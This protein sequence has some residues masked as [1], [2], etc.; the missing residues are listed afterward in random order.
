MQ[1]RYLIGQWRR[2]TSSPPARGAWAT[3]SAVSSS[4][5]AT[6]GGSTARK[7]GSIV[8]D[9]NAS[10]PNGGYVEDFVEGDNN[11]NEE[12]WGIC[13]KGAPDVR[14]LYDVYPRAAYYALR[15][16]FRLDPYAPGTDLGGRSAPTSQDPSPRRRRAE[17]R[18]SSRQ[19]RFELRLQRVRVSG[20]RLEFETYQHRRRANDHDAGCAQRRC[21]RAARRSGASTTCS[22]STS[23]SRRS[24]TDN[25]DREGCRST[26]SA[27]CRATRSTRSSTRTAARPRPSSPTAGLVVID[28]LERVKVYHA[29]VS[30]DDRWFALEGFYRTGHLH[31]GYQGDFFGLYRD[32]YYGE[33]IDIYNGEAPVGHRDAAARR[34]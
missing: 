20:V 8:H 5:G 9:T 6:A 15:S 13:A 27:T 24:P 18:G 34:R 4:S 3:P 33:N 11:M 29:A 14:G 32:A 25:G 23:T 1:A 10:W 2:S 19:S 22:R 30:W 31:W 12:W 26:S 21:R 7:T 16:A 17:A 28:G